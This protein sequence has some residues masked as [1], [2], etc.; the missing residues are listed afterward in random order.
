MSKVIHST[1]RV[2]PDM[3]QSCALMKSLREIRRKDAFAKDMK[4]ITERLSV[5]TVSPGM[6]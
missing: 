1:L 6:R 4:R 2:D 5:N 3:S